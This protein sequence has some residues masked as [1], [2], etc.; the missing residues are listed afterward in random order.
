M[1][2]ARLRGKEYWH[3]H[4]GI[5]SIDDPQTHVERALAFAP[6]LPDRA[7]FFGTT[8]AR[9]WGMPLPPLTASGDLH[10]AVRAGDRRV[11]ASGVHAH[12][13]SLPV[14]DCTIRSGVR[15]TTIERTWC[16]LAAHGLSLGQLV[17]AGDFAIRRR[18]RL[19]S[20]ASLQSAVE[21]YGSRRGIRQ[22]RRAL[23][24]LSDRSDSAPESELRVAIVESG[25]PVPAVNIPVTDARG[26]FLAQPDLSWPVQRLALEYEGE[27]HRTNRDQWHKD[28]ERFA[29]FQEA[30][31]T[32]L[33]ASAADYNDP[34]P[35]LARLAR[36][37][38][39]RHY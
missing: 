15:I 24:L 38:S 10:V 30:G 27:H 28:L 2:P 35:L 1:T 37:L 3:P 25:L 16:D 11:D 33:R 23:V 29:Q 17:A 22:L 6:R 19:A 7:F 18:S 5:R 13:I 12:H 31:W 34:A 39:P 26:R 20:S 8:A 32:V 14:S 36:I 9:L 21:R 4:W